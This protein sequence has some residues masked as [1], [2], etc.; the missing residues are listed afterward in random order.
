M[1]KV[2]DYVRTARF[3]GFEDVWLEIVQNLEVR[4]PPPVAQAPAASSAAGGGAGSG[5]GEE[6]RA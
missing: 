3:P 1:R 5:A 4:I 2:F 6:E